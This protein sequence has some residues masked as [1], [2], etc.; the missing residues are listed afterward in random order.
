MENEPPQDAPTVV[1]APVLP[2]SRERPSSRAP[3][4]STRPPGAVGERSKEGTGGGSTRGTSVVTPRETLHL[5][6]VTRTRTF[7]RLAFALAV[8]VSAT[9]LVLDGDPMAKRIF[10]GGAV[11]VMASTV[12]LGWTIREDIG[13]T[14]GRALICGFSCIFAAFAGIYFF[15]VFSPAPMIVPFG[16]CVFGTSLS[17]RGTMSVYLTCAI[18]EALLTLAVVM[19]VIPDPGLV[20]GDALTVVE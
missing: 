1:D 6:E 14:I 5:Q 10:L 7:V 20:R 15:G 8:L 2:R 18:T 16:L 9:M 4:A 13:Y 17:D 11:L 3:I 19:H 12:W